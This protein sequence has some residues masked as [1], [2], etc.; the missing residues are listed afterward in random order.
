MNILK[1]TRNKL[2]GTSI[3][4]AFIIFAITPYAFL[5]VLIDSFFDWGIILSISFILYNKIDGSFL[6]TNA[7]RIFLS[8]FIAKYVG[9]AYLALLGIPTDV[10]VFTNKIQH[11]YMFSIYQAM[12]GYTYYDNTS[13]LFVLSGIIVAFISIFLAH[14]L[15]GLRRTVLRTWQK[16]LV[17]FILAVLTSPYLFLIPSELIP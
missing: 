1:N 2:Y 5:Q 8:G 11:G 3:L 10:F 14:L 15:F 4:P 12:K 6:K 16:I 9:V 17:S 7:L 13:F